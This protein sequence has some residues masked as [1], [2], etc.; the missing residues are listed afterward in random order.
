MGGRA[1]RMFSVKAKLGLGVVRWSTWLAVFVFSLNGQTGSPRLSFAF[2]FGGSQTDRIFAIGTD[3]AQ[4]IYVAGDTDSKDLPGAP[5][6]SSSSTVA[7]VAKFD[8]SAPRL[9]YPVIL[10]GSNGDSARGIAV[11]SS[12]NAYVTGFTASS[13]FPVT[14]GA[15]QP[16]I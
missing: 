6:Y 12:G 7:F 13:N 5:A 11:D 8:P 10:G 2:S 16:Q 14:T 15:L 9:L 3:A 4:N 1:S